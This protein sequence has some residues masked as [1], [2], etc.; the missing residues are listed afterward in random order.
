MRPNSK[1][2][3]TIQ[4][5]SACMCICAEWICKASEQRYVSGH[6]ITVQ[7]IKMIQ[8]ERLQKYWAAKCINRNSTFHRE[9]FLTNL[10]LLR[11][12]AMKLQWTQNLIMH[13]VFNTVSWELKGHP[14]TKTSLTR[15]FK[16]S[17]FQNFS[18]RKSKKL[19]E[20]AKLGQT[21]R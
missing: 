2:V 5:K 7:Y 18:S 4:T 17:L 16:I 10:W 12:S 19:R 3:N 1:L 14:P 20:L 15:C 21:V 11:F 13:D 8:I 6:S 9:M